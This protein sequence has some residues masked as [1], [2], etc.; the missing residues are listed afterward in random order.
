MG[1]LKKEIF[2]LEDSSYALLRK[3]RRELSKSRTEVR[4][5]KNSLKRMVERNDRL[6]SKIS[7]YEHNLYVAKERLKQY[8]KSGCILE[9]DPS[10]DYIDKGEN[11]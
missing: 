10:L 7:K 6:L 8:R 11:V 3:A 5:L 9:P 1:S 2:K 4:I